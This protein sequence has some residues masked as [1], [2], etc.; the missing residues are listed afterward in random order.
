[1]RIFFT[2]GVGMVGLGSS[3]AGGGSCSASPKLH[4]TTASANKPVP[5]ALLNI[6]VARVLWLGESWRPDLVHVHARQRKGALAS[7]TAMKKHVRRMSSACRGCRGSAGR[8]GE[9]DLG[10]VGSKRRA[11]MQGTLSLN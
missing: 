4:R 8:V 10:S 2:C 6:W 1:V 9:D 7:A 11:V 3:L 5:P